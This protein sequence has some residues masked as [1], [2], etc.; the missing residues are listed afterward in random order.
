MK[1]RNLFFVNTVVALLFA[2]ALLLMPQ[3]LLLLYGISAGAADK[4]LG[5]FF[6]VQL[7]ISGLITLFARDTMDFKSQ[8]AITLS[9]FIGDGIGL[10]VAIGGT[11]SHT[12]NDLG[13]MVV[14]IYGFFAVAFGYFQF[15]G[16]TQ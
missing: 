9:H 14:V 16:P 13:W 1:L 6:G 4:L 11:L 15:F 8:R 2:L 10:I 5:Q 3:T 12:M 7:L